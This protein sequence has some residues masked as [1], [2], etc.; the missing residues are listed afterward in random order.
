MRST[1]NPAD[2]RRVVPS[3]PLRLVLEV[4]P[5]SVPIAGVVWVGNAEAQRFSGWLE[6]CALIERARS[7]SPQLF[8]TPGGST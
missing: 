1:G 4:D 3:T 6:L 8:V 2:T 7:D 5:G